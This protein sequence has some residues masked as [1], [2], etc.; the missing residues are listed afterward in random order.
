[1]RC[2][3]TLDGLL[4]LLLQ[5]RPLVTLSRRGDLLLGP[6][7]KRVDGPNR[8]W[9]DERHI[10]SEVT[11]SDTFHYQYSKQCRV[12]MPLTRANKSAIFVFNRCS[13]REARMPYSNCGITITFGYQPRIAKAFH[14]CKIM[15]SGH[16]V[17][18]FPIWKVF[19]SV[20]Y[21]WLLLSKLMWGEH[22][23]QGRIR[24][25]L[26]NGVEVSRFTMAVEQY[27]TEGAPN[28]SY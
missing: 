10:Y 17:S 24:R 11:E 4:R 13:T 21:C 2:R 20:G 15:G 3:A 25:R 9:I 14:M 6:T 18:R 26:S 22:G 27:A 23:V 1:M 8:R 28:A 5:A 7:H 16:G 12:G 19:T